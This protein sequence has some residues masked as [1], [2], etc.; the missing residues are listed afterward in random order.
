MSWGEEKA[1]AVTYILLWDG[2]SCGVAG[3]RAGSI[4]RK[5]N[6]ITQLQLRIGGRLGGRSELGFAFGGRYVVV[7]QTCAD[8]SDW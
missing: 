1:G 3:V 4:G 2:T 6:A 5:V 7:L 8:A